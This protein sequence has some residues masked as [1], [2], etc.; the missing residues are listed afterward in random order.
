MKKFI[1][2]CIALLVCLQSF[3]FAVLGIPVDIPVPELRAAVLDIGN[4]NKLTGVIDAVALEKFVDYEDI[5]NTTFKKSIIK[6]A[7]LGIAQRQDNDYF[8]PENLVTRFETMGYLLK[9]IGKD[10]G[11]VQKVL[12]KTGGLSKGSIKALYDEEYANKAI[13]EGILDRN[14]YIRMTEP[15]TREQFAIW[16]AKSINIE[17]IYGDMDR[18][19]GMKDYMEVTP[20]YRGVVEALLR[21][22]IM[23]SR[24]DGNF[25]PK[26]HI[27]RGECMYIL[28]KA[29]KT[30]YDKFGIKT[31]YGLITGIKDKKDQKIGYA[32]D[33]R[34]IIIRN[35][36]GKA[37]VIETDYNQKTHQKKDFIVYKA[38]LQFMS[39]ELRIGDEIYY[40]YK[41]GQV[42][43][44]EVPSNNTV[45]E[46]IKLTQEK[47]AN[48]TTYFGS[49]YEIIPQ[50]YTIGDKFVESSRFRVQT[51][52]GQTFDILVESDIH[53]GI[54]NDI[55]VY[56]GNKVGGT[57]LLKKGDTI[58]FVVKNNDSIVYI[59]DMPFWEK[60]IKG[61]LR[62]IKTSDKFKSIEIFGYDNVIYEYDMAEYVEVNVNDITANIEDLRYG[63]NLILTI[64][65]GYVTNIEAESFK[66]EGGYIPKYGK[67]RSGK[68]Y[69]VLP[70]GFVLDTGLKRESYKLSDDAPLTKG[71]VPITYHALKE[72]DYVKVFFDD[73]YTDT[74]SRMEVEGRERVIKKV[75]KGQLGDVNEAKNQITL[76]GIR[77]LK[78][79]YWEPLNQY[80][81][82]F[83]LD[84]KVLIYAGDRT[85]K[86]DDLKRHYRDKTVYVV[87]EEIFGKAVASQITLKSGGENIYSDTIRD[88]DNVLGRLELDNRMNFDI[89]KGTIVVKDGRLISSDLLKKSD[90]V[91]V[92]ADSSL[93]KNR[94]NVIK[95]TAKTEKVF[96]RVYV[97]LIEMVTGSYFKTRYWSRMNDNEWDDIDAGMS[98][99]FFYHTDTKIYDYTDKYNIKNIRML[100]FFHNGYGRKE[101]EAKGKYKG[102]KYKRYYTLFVLKGEEVGNRSVVAMKIRFKGFLEDQNIDDH[103]KSY[104]KTAD[105][106]NDIL[107]DMFLTRG[108]VSEI[109]NKWE[110]IKLTDSNDWITAAAEWR[111]NVNDTHVEYEDALFIK[112]NKSVSIDNIKLGD[113]LY[114]L[115]NNEKAQVIFISED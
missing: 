100:D 87:V 46:K 42:I 64:K 82:D 102:V 63:Q 101:N 90:N 22:G 67:S 51:F 57:D 65:Q 94:A 7:A 88:M 11:V 50:K 62:N 4:A 28:D 38:G 13:Q 25:A 106:L 45:I 18:V 103:I 23:D 69:K 15:V 96:D 114:I 105:K 9:L 77:Y 93:G 29:M 60:K 70:D 19:F 32:I 55:I 112:G 61:T 33:K 75:Y 39:D 104:S 84:D 85:V 89:T 80:A 35:V 47:G 59:S 26:A 73:L 108:V 48:L 40:I 2:I 8:Y 79:N 66:R 5:K 58:S 17:P 31:D 6:M 81:K 74:V 54:K 83:P 14:D 111:T 99:K 53:S 41:D 36:D 30:Q 86:I 113:E 110:R 16:L 68:L 37:T 76:T 92:V 98:D 49:I 115:R 56:K 27:S 109:D 91:M 3:S 21:D 78:N 71:G 107:E 95:M 44:S 12:P 24:N 72:G 34:D 97:G 1:T 52:D 20:A 10:D 43:Y